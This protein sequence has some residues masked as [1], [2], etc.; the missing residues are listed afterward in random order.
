[1]TTT[2]EVW[3]ALGTTVTL[4]SGY[5]ISAAGAVATLTDEI[6]DLLRR[7]KLLSYD[8][9]SVNPNPSPIPPSEQGGS[10]S[11]VSS[12]ELEEL[13]STTVGE[14]SATYGAATVLDGQEGLWLRDP[15]ATDTADEGMVVGSGTGRWNRYREQT[16]RLNVM[17]YGAKNDGVARPLSGLYGNWAAISAAYPHISKSG[18]ETDAA[19]YTRVGTWDV[20]DAV[21]SKVIALTAPGGKDVYFPAGTYRITR[22]IVVSTLGGTDNINVVNN[23]VGVDNI[24]LIGAGPSATFYPEAG[25]ILMWDGASTTLPMMTV[26]ASDCVVENFTFRVK[27]GRV[28]WAG[29]NIGWDTSTTRFVHGIEVIG[30]YFWADGPI[31]DTGV[32]DDGLMIFGVGIALYEPGVPAENQGNMED[33]RITRCMFR[34]QDYCAIYIQGG[35][36]F[37]TI[38]D[39]CRFWQ[40]RGAEAGS[41]S[42]LRPYA[43]AIQSATASGDILVS[44]CEFQSYEVVL[45]M[46]VPIAVTMI[47]STTEQCLQILESPNYSPNTGTPIQIIGARHF[48]RGEYASVPNPYLGGKPAYSPFISHA[49]SN[50]VLL[51]GLYIHASATDYDHAQFEM[52]FAGETNIEVVNCSF[53]NGNWLRR[54]S[55]AKVGATNI[56]NC[57][58]AAVVAPGGAEYSP[59]GTHTGCCTP[60]SYVDISGTDTYADVDTDTITPEQDANYLV[61][62]TP[63]SHA[64]TPT[65][66]FAYVSNQT[67]TSFRVNLGSAPGGGN[68]VRV[69]YHLGR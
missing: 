3:P 65:M 34:S 40:Y 41:Y 23:G 63:K 55:S 47:E 13:I 22:P 53:P 43:Y 20:N 46:L 7:S 19:A 32:W 9:T 12:A 25:T 35:Q 50:P 58:Y 15:S 6:L 45:R 27:V 28:A 61:H 54:G 1:M 30:C 16:N 36:P 21:I 10:F 24:R 18:G 42:G 57:L 51:Q 29:L 62:L 2:V 33:C 26:G 49:N 67:T 64:G 39:K 4:E 31:A 38:V 17:W 69:F 59:M 14:V 66:S 56:R 68:T 37:N 52:H 8:P 48:I 5:V 44:A 60:N 11:S